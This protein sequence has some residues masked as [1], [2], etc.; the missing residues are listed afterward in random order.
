MKRYVLA[1]ICRHTSGIPKEDV[2]FPDCSTVI[3]DASSLVTSALRLGIG[4]PIHII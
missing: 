3:Q 1:M 2:E 4:T